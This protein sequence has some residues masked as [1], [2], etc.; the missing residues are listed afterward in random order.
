[1]LLMDGS[2]EG[3]WSALQERLEGVLK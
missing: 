2:I 1:M 3:D